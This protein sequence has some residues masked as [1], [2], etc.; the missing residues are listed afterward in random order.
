MCEFSMSGSIMIGQVNGHA[1]QVMGTLFGTGTGDYSITLNEF[2]IL[3][4]DTAMP[5]NR[6]S[7]GGDEFNPLTEYVHGVLGEF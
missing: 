4:S 6:C 7:A 5:P 3:G 2:G 1:P